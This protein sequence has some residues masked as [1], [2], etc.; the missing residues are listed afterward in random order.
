[1]VASRRSRSSL[2][3]GCVVSVLFLVSCSGEGDPSTD[4]VQTTTSAAA[5]GTSPVATTTA[6]EDAVPDTTEPAPD[7]ATSQPE[8]S[9]E[10]LFADFQARFDRSDP[11][12]SL[13]VFCRPDGAP[14]SADAVEVVNIR[15]R[16]EQLEPLGFAVEIGDTANQVQVFID[17]INEKCGGVNGRLL[18]LSTVEVDAFS[19]TED[20]DV[21][22]NI[23][24]V[25]A[26]E[27]RQADVVIN[28]S[29][30]TGPGVLCITEGHGVPF[31]NADVHPVALFDRSGGLLFS[32]SPSLE[33]S[34]SRMAEF[35]VDTGRLE[36]KT[37]AVVLADVPGEEA[38]VRA[39]LV[40]RL[41]QAG[42][43]VAVV[44]LA[45]CNGG[46]SCT[47]GLDDI[48]AKMRR[49]GVDVVFPV[50]NILSLPA[51][52]SE[53]AVQGYEP[54]DVVFINSDVNAQATDLVSS[55]VV[56]FGGEAA[57]KLY[58][59]AVVVDDSTP[60]LFRDPAAVESPFNS[61]C[62]STYESA[63]G[64]VLDP[65]NFDSAEYGSVIYACAVIRIIARAVSGAGASPDAETIARAIENLGPVDTQDMVP[66]SFAPGKFEAPDV[67]QSFLWTWPCAVQGTGFGEENTC[68]VE[69]EGSSYASTR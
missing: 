49:D 34:L 39:A 60:A 38:A 56:A 45:G 5:T 48:V 18:N 67:V 16:L 36:G 68:F 59:G 20:I 1:M 52:V 62:V 9:V 30:F 55:K 57:G 23:A 29:A 17:F 43:E 22:R 31:V 28:T 33:S 12:Q 64:A 61:M 21:L 69:D 47:A 14:L 7:T 8:G 65:R 40:E 27:D 6:I 24:C 44:G 54:G 63:S 19:L 26:T 42:V 25:E 35:A 13:D 32:L 3:I 10:S 2:A 50:L 4:G 11:F 37:A 53:M 46:L 66:A 51:L 58:D 15:T 41:E